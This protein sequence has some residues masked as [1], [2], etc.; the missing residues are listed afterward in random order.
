M[1]EEAADDGEVAEKEGGV[2][3][4]AVAKALEDDDA[5]EAGDAVFGEALGDDEARAGEHGL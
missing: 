4:E 5:K 3:D 2:E 1:H